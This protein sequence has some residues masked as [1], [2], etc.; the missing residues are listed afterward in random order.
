M[1]RPTALAFIA[2]AV[3]GCAAQPA[4]KP[5]SP[6]VTY[7]CDDGRTV[8]AGY[9]SPTQAELR[10]DGRRLTLHTEVAASGVRYV[11]PGWQ[12]WTKGMHEASLAPL[13]AGESIAGAPG[14]ACHAP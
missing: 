14:V 10:F 4:Q 5:A 7:R 8:V 12:W 11:G 6:E 3:A 2:A 13:A 9:P 1:S